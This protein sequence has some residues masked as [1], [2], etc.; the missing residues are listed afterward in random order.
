[1]PLRWLPCAPRST[2]PSRTRRRRAR[3]RS[4]SAAGQLDAVDHGPV[5]RDGFAVRGAALDAKIE[6]G[7]VLVVDDL[8]EPVA[9]GHAQAEYARDVTR[10]RRTV[11]GLLLGIAASCERCDECEDAMDCAEDEYCFI[12]RDKRS[13]CLPLPDDLLSCDDCCNG[14]RKCPDDSA[15]SVACVEHR[16]GK[17]GPPSVDIYLT[18]ECD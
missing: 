9:L 3:S 18:A 8:G 12:K 2:T 4:P 5:E 13:L 14:V 7:V 17:D 10:T 1:M 15:P 16:P 6:E 11:V